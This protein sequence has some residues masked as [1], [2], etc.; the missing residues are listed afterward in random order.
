MS[1]LR[2]P[3]LAQ[4]GTRLELSSFWGPFVL[5]LNVVALRLAWMFVLPFVTSALR[6]GEGATRASAGAKL[7]LGWSEMR[8][9]VSLVIALA[10]PLRVQGGG[11][12]PIMRAS[13]SSPTR[14]PS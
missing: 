2:S 7:V 13:S 9:A 10:I 8:G 1:S 6:R 14:S 11:C 12:S 4:A 3:G 5:L